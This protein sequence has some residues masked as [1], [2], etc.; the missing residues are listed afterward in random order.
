MSG[1]RK[2][3]AKKGVKKGIPPFRKGVGKLHLWLGLASG[4]IICFL[5]ITGC[6]LAFQ[7]EIEEAT[8]PFR[9]VKERVQT[10]L[11]PS[12]LQEV[13]VRSLPGKK[14]HSLAYE[15]GRAAVASF[16]NTDPDY[17]YLVFMDPYS[18]KVLR[19]KDMSRD[20]FRVVI[21]GHFYLWLPPEIGQPIVASATL[22]FLVLIISGIILWWPRNKAARKQRFTVKLNARWRRV[23]YDLHNVLGFYMSWVIV[24]IAL[25]G[26]VW[27]FAW[28]ARSVFWVSSG[29]K[30][31]TEY[32]EAVSDTARSP[33]SREPAIDMAWQMMRAENPA[34][35]GIMDVHIPDSRHAAIEVALN[36]DGT[37]YWK[38]DYRYFD[39]YS[40]AEIKVEHAFGK[41]KEASGAQKLQR[42][43]YDIHVG[44]IAGLPGKILAFIASLICASMPV[45]GFLLWRGRKKKAKENV[46]ARGKKPAPAVS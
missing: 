33:V 10:P 5:G 17:Y 20:F 1:L 11:R 27:G 30:Q 6:I 3:A 34:Y 46:A 18:G 41:L 28:F 4:L 40:L 36:P 23:N 31:M 12:V 25:T 14:L 29:G 39:Q 16:Y 13:A 15:P 42:M 45:T 43:N 32:S 22:I 21:N 19:T 9:F 38:A 7:R 26:L 35:R 44:A 24:F 8:Q 2:Q 37:T